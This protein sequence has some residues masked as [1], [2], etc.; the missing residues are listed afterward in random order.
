MVQRPL[1]CC[2]VPINNATV[3]HCRIRHRI[4]ASWKDTN[5]VPKIIV[6]V[7]TYKRGQKQMQELADSFTK[8]KLWDA[9]QLVFVIEP[10]DPISNAAKVDGAWIHV[11]PEPSAGGMQ[12]ALNAAALDYAAKSDILG[13]VGDD[14]RFRSNDWDEQIMAMYNSK[15]FGPTSAFMY[16]PDGSNNIERELPTWWFMRSDVVKAL[17]WMALPQ[18]R[19]FFLD[20]AIR[21]LGKETQ[22]LRYMPD[23]YIEHMHFSFGKS[24]QDETYNHTMRVGSGDE[25][26]Y[27]QWRYGPQFDEDVKKVRAALRASQ[28][29]GASGSAS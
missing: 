13:F 27:R 14:H 7:P 19:H 28:Q 12:P 10:N 15:V 20:D 2:D 11:L 8:T 25:Y 3:C 26:R 18:C 5:M 9:T 22:S 1:P 23:V 24:V 16:G 6:L 17:G 4:R 21:E 29:F